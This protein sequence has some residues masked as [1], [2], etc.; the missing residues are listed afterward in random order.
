MNPTP[1]STEGRE[2]K[3]CERIRGE[4]SAGGTPCVGDITIVRAIAELDRDVDALTAEVARLRADLYDV[5]GSRAER[6]QARAQTRETLAPPLAEL[7]EVVM[8]ALVLSA[9]SQES[10]AAMMD[11]ST[12]TP[13]GFKSVIDQCRKYA[14]LCRKAIAEFAPPPLAAGEQFAPM[15]RGYF[16]GCGCGVCA[17]LRTSHG[18][19]SPTPPVAAEPWAKHVGFDLYLDGVR[20]TNNT[21][22][23]NRINARD[24]AHAAELAAKDREIERLSD[25]VDREVGHLLTAK[26][27]LAAATQRAEE[28]AA[29]N[30]PTGRKCPECQRDILNSDGVITDGGAWRHAHCYYLHERNVALAAKE[31]AEARL[32]AAEG[33]AEGLAKAIEALP[34]DIDMVCEDAPA[35]RAAAMLRELRAALA[36]YRTASTPAP[37]TGTT[38]LTDTEIEKAAREW[39]YTH[40]SSQS[41]E[42]PLT[43]YLAAFA[44]SLRPGT[45]QAG[46]GANGQA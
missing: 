46:E 37:A 16:S 10:I 1:A 21:D 11:G 12:L 41:A 19:A 26:R 33:R 35:P 18:A 27:D 31:S 23:A 8:R 25:I 6:E 36:A 13:L 30:R 4:L 9:E 22:A 5:G 43:E 28:A 7:P 34:V 14:A 44:K 29:R 3:N 32:T 17:S 2:R 24:S 38:G 39:F 42:M 15:C 40:G 45:A 20:V